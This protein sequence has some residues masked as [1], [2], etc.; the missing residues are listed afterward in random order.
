MTSFYFLQGPACISFSGGRTSGYMLRQILDAHGGTLPPDVHVLFANTGKERPETLDF[1]EECSQRWHVRVRWIEWQRGTGKR[2]YKKLA[3]EWR[4]GGGNPEELAPPVPWWREVSHATASRNG[5]PFD[6][7]IAWKQYLPNPVQRLCTQHLKIEVMR[8]FIL[9]TLKFEEW[10]TAVG[11]RHDEPRRWR[12][13]GEDSRNSREFKVGPLVKAGITEK[14]VMRFWSAQLFDLR[15]A[16]GEGN[17]DLCF[18]KATAIKQRIIYERPD[19]GE[20]WA[21]HEYPEQGTRRLWRDTG[22]PY[23]TMLARAKRQLPLFDTATTDDGLADC[24]CT[25]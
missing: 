22:L 9:E 8:L 1:V 7:L 25:D 5:E 20:W 2:E 16:Q 19:L 4:A 13:L 21:N 17:C 23:S 10:T 24:A 14:D 15:L 12:I 3:E 18:L 11:I 6:G